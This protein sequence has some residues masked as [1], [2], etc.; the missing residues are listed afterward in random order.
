MNDDFSVSG[1]I[2]VIFSEIR[3]GNTLM[4][5]MSAA[6]GTSSREASGNGISGSLNS[7]LKNTVL[8]VRAML[9]AFGLDPLDPQWL[10]GGNSFA[11]AASFTGGRLSSVQEPSPVPSQAAYPSSPSS[12]S[13]A[14]QVLNTLVS[15]QLRE[16]EEARRSKDFT[17][18]DAI[19]DMLAEAG[20]T[21]EDTPHGPA[22][23]L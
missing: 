11:A 10:P 12:P 19:R 21:I 13:R 3:R 17:R 2:A 6:A 16:R 14:A 9:D 22:W 23:K 4:A 1:A 5:S 8:S 7:D 18:A 15:A 20:I